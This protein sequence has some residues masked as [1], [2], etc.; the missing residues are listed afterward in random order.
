VD[1]AKQHDLARSLY[2]NVGLQDAWTNRQSGAAVRPMRNA[3]KY[4]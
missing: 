1:L 4:E 3:N 2:Y